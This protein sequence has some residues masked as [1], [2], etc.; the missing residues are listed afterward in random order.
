MNF[1]REFCE[2]RGFVHISGEKAI[3]SPLYGGGVNGRLSFVMSG[4]VELFG[5]NW[6]YPGRCN[7]RLPE[8]GLLSFAPNLSHFP[9]RV[10]EFPEWGGSLPDVLKVQLPG[11]KHGFYSSA[12]RFHGE[13]HGKYGVHPPISNKDGGFTLRG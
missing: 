4:E 12:L 11:C 6:K 13:R 3:L 5:V 1:A 9:F 10:S 7:F 8:I 2:Y